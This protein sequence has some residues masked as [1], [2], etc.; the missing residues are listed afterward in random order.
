MFIESSIIKERDILTPE[1][2]ALPLVKYFDKP[3][4]HMGP[5]YQQL[6]EKPLEL[7]DVLKIED[8]LDFHSLPGT[9]RQ[10]VFGYRE[11]IS[12]DGHP[13]GYF[14]EYSVYPG[15]TPEMMSWY[16]NWINIP[17][18]NMPKDQGNLRYK[19]WC[20]AGHWTHD[21][22]NKKDKTDG[23]M[24]MEQ[25]DLLRHPGTPYATKFIS[26]RH[27]ID[28]KDTGMPEEQLNELRANGVWMDP[29]YVEYFNLDWEPVLGS[30]LALTMSRPCPTGGME[31][32]Y[33]EYIGYTFKDGRPVPDP[34]TPAY[35]TKNEYLKM[36]L[37]H[38]ITESVHLST[39]LPELYAEYHDK[40]IDAD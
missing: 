15:A 14:R 12:D 16:Y 21:F 27:P 5:L 24:T 30:T 31:K 38:A 20:P 34:V 8:W 25:L 35:K 29:S 11:M 10:K 17:S 4:H 37:S 33:C 1:E 9:Y 32:V 36:I 23:I 40:P 19:I 6:I 7:E 39:F 2:R 26:V 22:I 3:L 13:Y 18:K 28:M